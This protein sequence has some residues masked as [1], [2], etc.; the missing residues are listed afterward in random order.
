MEFTNILIVILPVV[1]FFLM[2]FGASLVTNMLCKKF[3]QP[4]P[5]KSVNIWLIVLMVVISF[6]QVSNSP[7]TR[8]VNDVHNKVLEIN[9]LRR[10][11]IDVELPTLK[12]NSRKTETEDLSSTPLFNEAVNNK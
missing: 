9:Q 2:L 6:W 1:G 5:F 11:Q 8:P 10:E 4:F 3:K 12:D 7:I